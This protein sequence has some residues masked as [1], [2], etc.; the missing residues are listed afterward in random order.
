MGHR[1]SWSATLATRGKVMISK[2]VALGQKAHLPS[3]R[4]ARQYCPRALDFTSAAP[5]A[6]LPPWFV[7]GRYL[8]MSRETRTRIGKQHVRIPVT[9]ANHYCRH[10]LE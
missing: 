10:C 2:E 3:D 7:R 8:T 1:L 4:F 9:H 5:R 6:Q